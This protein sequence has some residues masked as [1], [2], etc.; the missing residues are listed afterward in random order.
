MRPTEYIDFVAT[1]L[2]VSE[3][4]G[5]KIDTVKR[6]RELFYRHGL[7]GLD[8]Y[9]RYMKLRTVVEMKKKKNIPM[10]RSL[11]I[12]LELRHSARFFGSELF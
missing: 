9:V 5:N 8:L 12:I 3:V 1:Q 2:P 11:I 7:P 6:M 4:D 10:E